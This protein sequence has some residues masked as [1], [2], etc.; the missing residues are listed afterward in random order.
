MRHFLVYLAGP[1][2]G[3]TLDECN[4]WRVEVKNALEE[5]VYTKVPIY[6]YHIHT[7]SP[8][9]GKQR[10]LEALEK[11]TIQHNYE[12]NPL[13]SIKGINTRDYFD[14]QRSDVIFVNLLG[15]KIV[16]IGT[17]MEIA[18]ARAFNKPVVCVME[19]DNIHHHSMLDYACGYIVETLEDGINILKAVL[20]PDSILD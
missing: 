6:G 7:L 8:L 10:V 16:S 20:G 3:C 15:A 18:W 1:I 13:T 5:R 4:D 11:S 17:V 2:T 12:T 9:R 19:K 14:V